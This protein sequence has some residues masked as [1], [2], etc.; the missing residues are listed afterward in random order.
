MARWIGCFS[1]CS[2]IIWLGDLNYRLASICGDTYD[3]LERKNWQA[4]F[5]KDQLR[6]ERNADR[7]LKGCEEGEISFAPTYKYFLNSDQYMYQTHVQKEA[8]DPGL[9]RQNSVERQRA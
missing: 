2:N 5:Q 1:C 3:L 8:E 4:L 7:V 6:I 9:V